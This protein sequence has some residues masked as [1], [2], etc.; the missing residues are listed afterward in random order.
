MAAEA[1]KDFFISYNKADKAWAEWIAWELE[2]AG[3]TTI[4]QAWDFRPGGNFVLEMQ[5]AA[6]SATRTIAVLSPDYLTAEFPQPEW[7][8]A[9]AQ[10]PTGAKGI[11]VPVRV[12]KVDLEGL[13]GQIIY[14][15]LIGLDEEAARNALISGIEQR[16]AKPSS[17]LKFPDAAR[18]REAPRFPGSL[19]PIWNVPH[20]RNPNF[21][22]REQLLKD[23]RASLTAG[24]ATALT[25]AALHGLGGIGKTQLALEYAHRHAPDYDLVWWLRAE[26]PATLAGD[27]ADLAGPLDL[28]EKGAQEQEAAVAAVRHYLEQHGRWLLI[29][30]NAADPKD[31]ENYLPRGGSGYILIT[32]R[33]AAWRGT[34]QPLEVKVWPREEAIA[35]LLKRTGEQDV[36]A[37]G[38]LAQEL[39]DLPLALE[40]AAAYMEA[41]G[42]TCA[43]YLPRF[44]SKRRALLRRGQWSRDYPATVAT[45]WDISFKKLQEESPAGADLL[46]LC[47]FWAP[48]D[49]PRELLAQGAKHLPKKLAQVVNDPMALEAALEALQR[50]SLMAVGGDSLAVHRLVQAVV[51]DRLHH[52]AR[53]KWAGVAV[54]MVNAALSEDDLYNLAIWP[55]YDRL[56]P[57]ALAAG[58]HASTFQVALAA[59]GRVLN[60][61]GC[62]LQKRAEFMEARKAYEGALALSEAAYGPIHPHV[63]TLEHNLGSVLQDQGDLSGARSH[64]ERALAMDEAGC[65]PNHPRV[66]LL[67]NSVGS[68]LRAQGD[69]AGAKSCYERALAIDEAAYGPDHPA[70]ARDANNLGFVFQ[71]LGDLTAAKAYCERSLAIGE[72]VYGPDHPRVAVDLTNLGSV[73]QAQGDQAAAKSCYERA[74]SI[75]AAAYGPNH[76]TVAINANN[77]AS[78][79]LALGDVEGARL[80]IARALE[81]CR[82]FLGDD[83]PT[84][85]ILQ[86]NFASL[87]LPDSKG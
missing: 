19:P 78:V 9:F 33:Y 21:T 17:A 81:T 4:L 59:G 83:H 3:Y 22:G 77:L 66:A 85:K 50:C 26:T 47:A 25:Q 72:A 1:P 6:A 82:Q 51:R 28:P 35:F 41:C 29:F 73:L 30:D 55:W 13:L 80:L 7:A 54:E 56:L 49:I 27:Y 40:Q 48:D 5:K 31:L 87:G 10:D 12:S 70:V 76:P 37:A 71:A 74:L 61:A 23:L 84:T 46:N 45:T 38:V 15:N 62:Y 36:A 16:R 79:L 42:C 32:S 60:Q 65:G 67:L 2:A 20:Q 18:P 8:A 63:A 34:A 57:H 39:G 11:M 52:K 58:G 43:Q 44:R 86:D 75:D 14:I 68:V 64:Y 69:L 53:Q 24:Q